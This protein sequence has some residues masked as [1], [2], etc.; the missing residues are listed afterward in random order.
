MAG[1]LKATVAKRV[2]GDK[3]SPVQA[4][5]A[6]AVAG[7]ATAVLTYRIMRS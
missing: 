3:P 6:A 4:A 1:V 2:A 7:T 5:L